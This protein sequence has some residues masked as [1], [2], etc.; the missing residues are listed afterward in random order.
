MKPTRASRG[1]VDM[2]E[3]KSQKDKLEFISSRELIEDTNDEYFK[4]KGRSMRDAPKS[5]HI[6][7]L[8]KGE[9]SKEEGVKKTVISGLMSRLADKL[10]ER[11]TMV[12]CRR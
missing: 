9:S 11:V 4:T 6:D 3:V 8:N 12:V 5:L 1:V 10:K 2:R 7:N